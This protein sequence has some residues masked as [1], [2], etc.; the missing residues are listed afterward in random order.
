MSG[1][2]PALLVLCWPEI[3]QRLPEEVVVYNM[4]LLAAA[5]VKPFLVRAL[6]LEKQLPDLPKNQLQKPTCS[7]A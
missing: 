1:C 5:Q 3:V 7:Y 2:A 6:G 4:A